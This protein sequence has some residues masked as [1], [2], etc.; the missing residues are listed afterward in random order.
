MGWSTPKTNWNASHDEAGN[1]TGDY[2]NCS[3]YNRIKEN[4]IYLRNIGVVTHPD[5]VIKDLGTDKTVEDYLYADEVNLLE[6]TLD[7]IN[8][9][10]LNMQYG[11]TKT[12]AEN[13]S[14]ID[15][16]ELNRIESAILDLYNRITNEAAGRRKFNWCFGMKGGDL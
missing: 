4:L 13:G 15:A 5:F 6:E 9:N 1:Y 11:N 3:D 12:F 14:M 16:D 8:Q 7:T 2:F 10:T